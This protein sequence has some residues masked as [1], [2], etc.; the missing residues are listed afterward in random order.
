M[1]DPYTIISMFTYHI[2]SYR[3]KKTLVKYIFSFNKKF[4]IRVKKIFEFY[5]I[6]KKFVSYKN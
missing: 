4:T 6:F 1:G 2:I 5:N 3:S